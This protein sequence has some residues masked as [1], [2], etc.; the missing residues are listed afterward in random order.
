MGPQETDVKQSLYCVSPYESTKAQSSPFCPQSPNPNI[1]TSISV[2]NSCFW[3]F[4]LLKFYYFDYANYNH[5]CGIP[6]HRCVIFVV[7][8]N[9]TIN[10]SAYKFGESKY[11]V[12]LIKGISQKT[13]GIHL[14]CYA[15]P[16]ENEIHYTVNRALLAETRG[17]NKGCD[18]FLG[19]NH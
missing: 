9:H 11:C 5:M 1:P 17:E 19:E 8:E 18:F 14:L 7:D 4:I 3:F 12:I 15:L 13:T 16:W 6:G 2:K 10:K